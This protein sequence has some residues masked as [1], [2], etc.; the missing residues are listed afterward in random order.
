M[1]GEKGLS[2]GITLNRE[3]MP[4]QTPPPPVL[5]PRPPKRSRMSDGSSRRFPIGTAIVAFLVVVGSVGVLFAFSGAKVAV[6]P[7]Q[8][9]VQVTSTLTAAAG[10]GDLPFGVV[11]V[12]KTATNS[13]ESESTE[14][15]TQSAQG[16][17]T[18]TNAQEASQA[19]IKNTRF[20]TPEGLIFRIKDSISVPPQKN[21]TPGSLTVTVY[22]DEA[23]ERHNVGPTTFTLPGLK[24]SDT[25][26][27]VT[28][29][30]SES[31]QGGFLGAR[32]AVGQATKNA[33]NAKLQSTLESQ[34]KTELQAQV[35]PGYVLIPG[36]TAFVYEMQPDTA[37]VGNSVTLTTKG[38]AR[39]VVFP[40]EALARAIA[41]QSVGTY[42]GQPLT[43][44]SLDALSLAPNE[45][46][47]P[48]VG[49]TTF[50]FTLTGST[51]LVWKIDTSRI[52]AAVAG[53][54]R[55]GA[56][57]VLEGF[58]EVEGA[59]LV[60]KP[61]WKNTFPVEPAKITVTIEGKDAKNAIK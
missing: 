1:E 58:P 30:S 36:G 14:N 41:F 54:S 24:G 16:T 27:K 3:Q 57:E 26:T 35:K 15:V 22:A 19:L 25:Y 56:H 7:T 37:G 47:I 17:I 42:S 21:G 43:F 40:E 18:V 32:P 61:F 31:M 45:G 59:L 23:G 34:L 4:L 52:A 50:S 5:P 39:G 53:K 48:V 8:N 51:T 9:V 11:V 33:E 12:E 49:D 20:E 60:L 10:E 13:V 28:A 46:L 29:R 2:S 55:S 38:S 44:K 6:T